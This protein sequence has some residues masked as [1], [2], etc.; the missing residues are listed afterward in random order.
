[1]VLFFRWKGELYKETLFWSS[2]QTGLMITQGLR[3]L[4]GVGFW[5]FFWRLNAYS[6]SALHGHVILPLA[7]TPLMLCSLLFKTDFIPALQFQFWH[8][9]WIDHFL[10]LQQGRRDVHH[11]SHHALLSYHFLKSADL[12]SLVIPLIDISIKM[13]LFQLYSQSYKTLKAWSEM[14]KGHEALATV[15]YCAS[16]AFWGQST[17]LPQS[18]P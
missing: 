4:L 7:V 17:Q 1:M 18:Y 9:L 12:F 6:N 8:N 14:W 11:C 3:L 15:R 10:W 2:F 5:W 16:T 13:S